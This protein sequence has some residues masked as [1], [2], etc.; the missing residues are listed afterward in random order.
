[1]FLDTSYVVS[2]GAGLPVTLNAVGTTSIN[3]Q[4]KGS[5]DA[6]NFLKTKEMDVGTSINPSIALDI[7]GTMSVDAYFAST[8]IKLK[9]SMHTTTAIDAHLK[10]RGMKLLSIKFGLPKTTNEIIGVR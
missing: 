9:T 4:L 5:L 1:M 7:V 3:L 2:S 8:G 6:E 10:I